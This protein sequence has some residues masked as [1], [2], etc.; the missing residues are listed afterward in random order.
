V[1]FRGDA[2]FADVHI[3]GAVKGGTGEARRLG[4]RKAQ[5]RR[6]EANLPPGPMALLPPPSAI[7]GSFVAASN[8]L[9]SVRTS[10]GSD[11]V[12][13]TL[14]PLHFVGINL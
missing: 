10:G 1:S 4:R 8:S 12:S 2:H 5:L 9:K 11:S 13:R 7:V 6:V 3:S 14:S